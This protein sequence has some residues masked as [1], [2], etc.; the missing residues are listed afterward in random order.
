M[1]VVVFY[2]IIETADW[3]SAMWRSTKRKE[4][5]SID[6]FAFRWPSHLAQPISCLDDPV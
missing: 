3:L 4:S 6:S 2:K 1:N 5:V